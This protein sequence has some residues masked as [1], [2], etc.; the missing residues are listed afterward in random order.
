M[1]LAVLPHHEA[2]GGASFADSPCKAAYEY[3][4]L[5]RAAA[6]G[7]SV[8][9]KLLLE[10]GADANGKGYET[11]LRCILIGEFSSPLMIAVM[12][13][14]NEMARLLLRHGANPNL[15]EAESVSPTDV[16]RRRGDQQ[17]LEILVEH[18]GL[19]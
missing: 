11:A 19:N 16:A 8:G 13:G 1:M 15:R 14:D 17:M 4:F 9:A 3:H 7:D 5:N 2:I 10:G 18:G 12:G 6:L